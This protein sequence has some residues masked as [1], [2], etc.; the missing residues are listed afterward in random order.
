MVRNAHVEQVLDQAQLQQ[1]RHYIKQGWTILCR[2]N[3]TLLQSALDTKVGQSGQLILYIAR[4]EDPQQIRA[5]LQ[6]QFTTEELAR[7]EIRQVPENPET[8]KEAGLLYLPYPYIVPG[9]RFNEMYGWDSYFTLLGLV[10]DGELDL[11]KNMTDNCIYEIK[12]YGKIL[13]A[14]RTYYLTRSQPP[15]LT[16]MILEVFNRTEDIQWLQ[17]TL[18]AI[19]QYYHYWVSEP[20]LTA[21]TGLSRYHGGASTPAPE[22]VYG[23]RDQQGKTHYDRVREYYHTHSVHEYDATRYYD[24]VADQL[25]PD[26]YVGDRAV[27]ESGFDPADRFGPFS[28]DIIHYNPVDLNSLLYQMEVDIATIFTR[29][30]HSR[31]AQVWQDR[32][33]LRAAMLNRLMWNEE[34]GLYF[35]YNFELQRP[36][37]YRF[38]TTFYPLWAG[39]AT[40]EQASKVVEN[41]PIFEQRGG[42]QMSDSVTGKQ[43]DAPFGWAPTQIIAIGGL[44]R[45]G[46]HEAADRI[47]LKFLTMILQDFAIHGTLKEKYNV[48]TGQSDLAADLKFGYTSNEVGFGWTNAAFTL[49]YEQLRAG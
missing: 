24:K 15:F 26:F 35:D 9:G 6:Q 43:W 28:A 12:H 29:L 2:S 3:L 37:S 5:Q 45:Y 33:Q 20:H 14:N 40:I 30:G 17:S 48:V 44:R 32:A 47:S 8:I 21:T 22:A 34:A 10:R 18:P 11:A 7:V 27:R 36:S 23:E 19:E 49:L 4:S 16:Q 41:L 46:F 39:I 42:L 13:N 1:V 38:I 31:P 25:S